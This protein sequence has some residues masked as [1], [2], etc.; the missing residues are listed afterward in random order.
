VIMACM[1]GSLLMSV[2]I[3]YAFGDRALLF[4]LSYVA[5]QVGRHTFL[6][7]GSGTA[8]SPERARSARIL[9]YFCISA[10]FLVAGALIEDLRALLWIIGIGIEVLGP[11]SSYWLPAVG[12]MPPTSW[13]VEAEHFSER[14]QLFIIIALGETIVITGATTSDLELEAARAGAFVV[15]F[16]GTAALWWLYFNRAAER[17]AG[18]LEEAG[19]ARTSMARDAFTYLHVVLVAGIIV[20]AVGD[21]LV[22]A[23]PDEHLPIEE[24][25]AV[26]GGPAIYL[27]GQA[28]IRWRVAGSVSPQRLLA[29]FACL[30]CIAF[31]TAVP[32]LALAAVVVAILVA[33]I[34]YEE[35]S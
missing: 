29:A 2:A 16:L 13:V 4:A 1:L 27:L 6:T 5:I 18:H 28:L 7:F 11:I 17:M 3:P 21:E 22:I 30:A 25:L 24:V 33:V 32:G 31:G 34:A 10:V 26:C 15:A 8:G 23:H 9:T 14:F 12:K 35:L 19:E 20:S